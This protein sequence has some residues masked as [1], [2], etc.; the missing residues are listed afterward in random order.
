[1]SAV[2][3]KKIAII[4]S[5]SPAAAFRDAIGDFPELEIQDFASARELVNSESAPDLGLVFAP[6][7]QSPVEIITLLGAGC[8]VLARA[9]F[10]RSRREALPVTET[11]ERLGRTLMSLAPLRVFE[12]I[13]RSKALLRAGEI[14]KLREVEVTIARKFDP[15]RAWQGDPAVSGGGVWMDFGPDSLDLIEAIAGPID[16]LRM[17]KATHRQRTEVEDEAIVELRHDHGAVS[18]INLSWNAETS[19]P[20]ARCRGEGGEILIG[21]AQSVLSTSRGRTI[22]ASGFDRRQVSVDILR[23]FLNERLAKDPQE[24]HGD[25]TLA[26]LEAGYTSLKTGR[27]EIA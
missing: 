8:D 6:P 7:S 9:P 1:M 15:R 5:V 12:A 14:G 3:G 26:W 19:A 25:Q 16:A 23:L 10:A 21:W 18:R 22:I 17:L 2:S 24:D 27:W 20:M 4:G 11:A 13:V